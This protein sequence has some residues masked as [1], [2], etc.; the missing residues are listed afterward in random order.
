MAVMDL[1]MGEQEIRMH[2]I[3][4]ECVNILDDHVFLDGEWDKI[5]W[6]MDK[7]ESDRLLRRV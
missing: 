2:Y 1:M 7:Y 4:T 5:E 3:S 6:Q